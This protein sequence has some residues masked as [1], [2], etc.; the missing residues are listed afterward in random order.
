LDFGKVSVDAY[1]NNL[2]DSAGRTSTTGTTVF[3]I[4]PVYP[5]G[6]MGTGVIRPRSIGLS[7]TAGL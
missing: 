6:A 2:F 7:L 4:L 3:G 1:V 5:N